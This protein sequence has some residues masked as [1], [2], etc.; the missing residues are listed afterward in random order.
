MTHAEEVMRPMH[1]DKVNCLTSRMGTGGNQIPVLHYYDIDAQKTVRKLT[2]TECERLQGLHDGYT[3]IEFRG[4][5]LQSKC[6]SS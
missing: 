5:D 4:M 3:D 2:P 6:N 1:G